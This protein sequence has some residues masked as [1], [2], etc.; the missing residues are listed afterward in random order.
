MVPPK[1]PERPRGRPKNLTLL[2][3]RREEILEMAA[4]VFAE[5][6]F[7]KTDLQV[8]ADALGIGKGTVYRYFPSKHALFL[9]AVDRGMRLLLER[10]R[11]DT[12]KIVDPLEQIVQAIRSYLAFFD[13]HPELIEL[14]IQERA[15]FRNR[16]HSTYF[17][18]FEANA[19]RWKEFFRDLIRTKRFRK[20]DVEDIMDG[21]S[22]FLYGTI[23]TNHFAG[24]KET[25]EIQSRRILNI[26]F[27]GLLTDGERK[28]LERGALA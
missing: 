8:V 23:F 27:L 15:E 16:K 14:L 17:Q 28:Q 20:I 1:Q 7:P 10:L 13:D 4:K 18:H 11:M 12:E 9:S 19:E 26:A 3:R 5:R 6:G 24:R 21:L 22:D 25:F 2:T